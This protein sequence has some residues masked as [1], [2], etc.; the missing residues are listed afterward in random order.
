MSV[1]TREQEQG[2]DVILQDPAKGGLLCSECNLVLRDP[3]QT[4]E[5]NRL[6][7]PCFKK[8]EKWDIKFI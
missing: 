3:V 2:Y 4:S 7:S 6:C 1:V 5:G 8:I